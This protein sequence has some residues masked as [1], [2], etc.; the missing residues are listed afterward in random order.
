MA[1]IVSATHRYGR[2]AHERHPVLAEI[3]RV[4]STGDYVLDKREALAAFA[5]LDGTNGLFEKLSPVRAYVNRETEH[6]GST[7]LLRREAEEFVLANVGWA[8]NAVDNK[9]EGDAL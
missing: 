4:G 2:C 7:A 6:P 9:P 1:T 5:L 3:L 8:R